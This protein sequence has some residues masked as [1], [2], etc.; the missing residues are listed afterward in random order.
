MLSGLFPQEEGEDDDTYADRISKL[1]PLL[2]RYYKN[3]NR[4]A[5]PQEIKDFITA[6]TQE[7]M[8]KGGRVGL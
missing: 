5:S 7:Y 6:N 8:A 1:E 3:V 2:D 4:N